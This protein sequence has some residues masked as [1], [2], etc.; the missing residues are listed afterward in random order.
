MEKVIFLYSRNNLCFRVLKECKQIRDKCKG[1][2]CITTK[3]LTT[4]P[5]T[6][7]TL[8]WRTNMN[9]RKY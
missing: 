7:K 4:S 5:L 9:N 2:V 8:T 1:L 6:L 3:A